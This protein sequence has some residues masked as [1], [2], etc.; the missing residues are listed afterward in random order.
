M[1]S[2]RPVFIHARSLL[3]LFCVHRAQIPNGLSVQFN[4]LAWQGVGHLNAAG[5]GPR[6]AFGKDFAAEGDT[7][8]RT[9]QLT[10]KSAHRSAHRS[11][12][13]R[14]YVSQKLIAHG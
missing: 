3:G 2:L 13:E 6:N 10:V 14:S 1:L 8:L 11:L 5:G 9:G 4:G 12:P 7:M